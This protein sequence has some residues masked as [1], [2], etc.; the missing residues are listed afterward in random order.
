VPADTE[1][2][3]RF[4]F[5]VT[6]A[7][8]V[9]PAALDAEPG[10]A[11]V[12]APL[13]SA[14]DSS[15]EWSMVI[16]RLAPA[17]PTPRLL[18]TAAE[19]GWDATFA[20]PR[21]VLPKFEVSS[22]SASIAVKLVLSASVMMLLIPGWR[23]TNSPGARAIE[24]ESSMHERAWLRQPAGPTKNFALYRAAQGAA[25]YRMDFTWKSNPQGV[26][27]IFRAKDQQNY[28]A[29]RIKPSGGAF[30]LERYAVING[31]EKSRVLRILPSPGKDRS[32]RIAT[33]VAGSTFRLLLNGNPVSQWTDSRITSGGVGFLEDGRLP[34]GLQAVRISLPP[35]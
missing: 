8:L 9:D 31:V 25:D 32:L 6:W 28:F 24:M 22:V 19:S 27:W 11:Q 30:S 35:Q 26:S 23:N 2:S 14:A 3:V 5:P 18:P 34:L 10:L 7:S 33:D 17:S 4:R 21:Y 13:F 16:P 15:T 12:S 20:P 1:Q 29:A